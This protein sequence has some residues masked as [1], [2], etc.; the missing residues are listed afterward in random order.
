MASP[1]GH[2]LVG[3]TSAAVVARATGTDGSLT[4][5]AGAFVASGLPDLDMLLVASG[6]DLE[7]AHRS[8][9][10][11]LVALAGLVGAVYWLVPGVGSLDGGILLAWLAAVVSHPL[12]DVVTTGPEMAGRGFGIPLFWPLSK[13]RFF[14]PRPIVE[15]EDLDKCRSAGEV[16]RCLRPEVIRFSPLVPVALL[17]ILVA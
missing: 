10:H 13:R 2:A 14:V 12:V 11:S 17:L 3:L 4:L 9:S 5:W 6:L 1:V 15:T 8:W 16:W 7:K